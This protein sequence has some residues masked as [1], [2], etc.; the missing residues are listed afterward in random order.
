MTDLDLL[1]N[2]Y[3]KEAGVRQ[4]DRLIA[5]L[6]RKA[7][8]QFLK[9]EKAKHVIIAPDLMKEWLGNVTFKKTSLNQSTRTYW[10]CYG[11]CMD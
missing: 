6:M 5:K 11:T 10:S 4:L 1:I 3:T 7:I 2:E 9:D 8:Q